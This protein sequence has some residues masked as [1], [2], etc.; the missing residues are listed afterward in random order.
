MSLKRSALHQNQPNVIK[1]YLKHVSFRWVLLA[2]IVLCAIGFIL[3]NRYYIA[4]NIGTKQTI[5]L[6]KITGKTW[7]L[8]IG[9]NNLYWNE[10]EE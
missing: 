9:T 3:L 2:A 8:K 4:C 10:I 5:L 6:D 7:I 1:E